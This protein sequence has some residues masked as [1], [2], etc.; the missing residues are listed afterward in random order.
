MD[1]PLERVFDL[2]RSTKMHVYSTQETE[3]RLV[4]GAEGLLALDDEVT[5]EAVHLGVRQRLT[6]RVTR[7]ERPRY[8]RDSMVKGAFRRFDHDHEFEAQGEGTKVRE[9]FD[10]NAPWGP[11]GVFAERLFLTRYMR[12]FL[13]RRAGAIKAVAESDDWSRYL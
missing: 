1:A 13:K 5:W 8:F 6:A 7:F 9:R 3:E 12:Q 2:S 4:S 11:I 10:F